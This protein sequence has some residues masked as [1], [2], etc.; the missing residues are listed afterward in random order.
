M[1][2]DEVTEDPQTPWVLSLL[3]STG[4]QIRLENSL[5]LI[6]VVTSDQAI[7]CSMWQIIWCLFQIS[8]VQCIIISQ[9]A[10]IICLIPVGKFWWLWRS[11]LNISLSI[12]LPYLSHNLH[13]RLLMTS[14]LHRFLYEQRDWNKG[15]NVQYKE[16]SRGFF[17]LNVTHLNNFTMISKP[18]L[19]WWTSEQDLNWKPMQWK[20][21]ACC[22]HGYF[23]ITSHTTLHLKIKMD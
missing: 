23:F 18:S 19:S 3:P 13:T 2:Q 21:A 6:Y 8:I 20:L 15:R 9:N 7:L 17:F 10:I 4:Q 5:Q 12:S 22:C 1:W 14:P 11:F 16:T